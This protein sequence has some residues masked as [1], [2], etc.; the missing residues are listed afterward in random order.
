MPL[1]SLGRIVEEGNRLGTVAERCDAN[2]EEG[3]L[4]ESSNTLLHA[5]SR[6]RIANAVA[7]IGLRGI[8]LHGLHLLAE[9]TLYGVIIGVGLLQQL[10]ILLSRQTLGTL[11]GVGDRGQLNNA[12]GIGIGIT[13]LYGILGRL[14]K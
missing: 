5:M 4:G 12:N 3:T 1:V 11:L 10:L 8:D 9:T 6:N 13:H 14:F 2:L 7:R